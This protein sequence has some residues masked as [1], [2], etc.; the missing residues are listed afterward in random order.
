MALVRPQAPAP[1]QPA[2]DERPAT[3]AAGGPA[4]DLGAIYRAHAASV[5]RWAR[6]LLGPGGDVDDLVH[7]VFLVA[8]RRLREF[9]GDARITTW[10][11]AIT[12]RIAL[13]RRR[14]ERWRRWWPLGAEAGTREVAADAPTPLEALESRRAAELTYRILD[15]LSER[16]RTA[17][18]LFE[19]EGLS[20][21]EIAAITGQRVGSVWVRLHRA[22]TRFL[23][24]LAAAEREGMSHG[25]GGQD[26]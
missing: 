23:A 2:A 6:R 17:L 19:L 25:R 3:S 24:A 1:P 7:E 4:I 14:R 10:L 5:S 22:R 12:V 15:R 18:I 26:A 20:G 21:D 8:Q 9:R 16:D 11:Y 13:D